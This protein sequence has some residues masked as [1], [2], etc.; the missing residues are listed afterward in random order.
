MCLQQY[1][2]YYTGQLVQVQLPES[3]N[4]VQKVVCSIMNDVEFS[5]V[6]R[7]RDKF[8]QQF[9]NFRREVC[10]ISLVEP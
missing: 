8:T 4:A 9:I 10:G 5:L 6:A 2:E 7:N 3:R 1:F